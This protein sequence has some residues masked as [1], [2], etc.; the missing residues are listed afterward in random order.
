MAEHSSVTIDGN[1]VVAGGDF[2]GQTVQFL[3]PGLSEVRTTADLPQPRDDAEGGVVYK[4]SWYIT[5]GGEDGDTPAGGVD[6][7]IGTPN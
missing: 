7:L 6:V 5:G 4:G 1:V 3:P 2:N